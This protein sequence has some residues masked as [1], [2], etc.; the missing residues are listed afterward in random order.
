MKSVPTLFA[1]IPVAHLD[2]AIAW[3]ERFFGRE[4]DM[5]PND[6][7]AVWQVSSEGWVYVVTDEERA[8]S[9]LLTIIVDD[10]DSKLDELEERGHRDR[11]HR[12]PAQ[13]GAP[14]RGAATP[15]TTA[16]RSASR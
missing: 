6:R 16:S 12:H 3:Y 11:A 15:R 8:G 9:G 14:H 1:G 5:W 10:L 7:E 4:P 13:G 2:A